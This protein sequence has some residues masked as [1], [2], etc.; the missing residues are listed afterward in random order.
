MT[1]GIIGGGIAGL[2][3]AIALSKTGAE[4][5]IYEKSPQF[6]EVGAGLQ[7]GPN[8]VSALKQL[9]AFEALEPSTVAPQN[10][11]I[12]DGLSGAL[13]STL[14][15]GARFEAR[16]GQPYRVSHRADLLNA[17]LATAKDCQSVKLHLNSQLARLDV[18]PDATTCHF[19]N[20]QQVSHEM[21][22]GA[23]GFRSVVR[24]SVLNDGPPIF[25]GHSLYR[26][27]IPIKD[28]PDIPHIRD[29][30]LWLYPNGHVVHYPVSAG[31]NL[32]I[33]AASEQDWENKDWSTPA[34]PSEVQSY[35]A[36]APRNLQKVL[37]APQDWLKWA[38]AGHP[39]SPVWSKHK[40]VLI[41]DAIHPTLP[42]LAQGAAMAMEDA[43]CLA[44][45][46]KTGGG[47]AS[48]TQAR[49]ERTRKIVE[50]SSRL[51]QIYHMSNPKRLARNFVIGHTST[52]NQY[53]RLAWLYNWSAPEL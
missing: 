24:R 3:T 29:V 36:K 47:F 27:L 52:K 21:L 20:S 13:L 33:V 45:G 2:A 46:L 25:A 19:T 32:N 10:I 6:T 23:D 28:A 18:E 1:I 22:V 40:I 5:D 39:H 44:F 51:G 53:N 17:L 15:L 9:G 31:K 42:Y 35:F 7:I 49:Q 34:A 12:M 14:P 43:V 50:T 16:F 8:A 11:R 30:N 26:A 38:A 37:Q 41:G 4:V 48:Y